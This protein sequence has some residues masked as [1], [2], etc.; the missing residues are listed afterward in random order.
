MDGNGTLIYYH[1]IIPVKK[2]EFMYLT[3]GLEHGISNISKEPIRLLIM[4]YKIPE[5]TTVRLTEILMPANSNDVE[6]QILGQHGPTTQ[7]ILLIGNTSSR[8]DKLAAA[9]QANSLFIMD[10]ATSATNIPHNHAQE[11]ELL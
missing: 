11:K 1:E 5:R 3:V 2:I 9:G 8:R 10:S 6:L 7:F 4:G